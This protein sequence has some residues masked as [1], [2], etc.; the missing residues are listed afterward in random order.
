MNKRSSI[1]RTIRTDNGLRKLL[2]QREAQD[3]VTHYRAK[4]ESQFL[5]NVPVSNDEA[6]HRPAVRSTEVSCNRCQVIHNKLR[7]TVEGRKRLGL[8]TRAV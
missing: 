5:C 3:H 4:D 8:D 7:L 2:K 1:A 6:L